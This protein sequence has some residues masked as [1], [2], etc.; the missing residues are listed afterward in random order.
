MSGKIISAVAAAILLSSTT[1][2]SAQTLDSPQYYG[3][4]PACY[5]VASWTDVHAD[6]CISTSARVVGFKLDASRLRCSGARG[7]KAPIHVCDTLA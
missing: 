5:P 1:L 2:T 6:I 7:Q 3:A 4:P